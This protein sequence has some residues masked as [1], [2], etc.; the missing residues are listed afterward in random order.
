[1]KTSSI[2]A[3]LKVLV[4]VMFMLGC[5]AASAEKPKYVGANYTNSKSYAVRNVRYYLKDK[6]QAKHHKE[7]G[8]ASWYCCYGKGAKTADGSLYSKHSMTAAHKTLP[9]GSLVKVTNTRN[10]KSVTVEINDRGPFSK[11]RVIDLTPAAFAAIES[12]SLGLAK[13]K[14]EVIGFKY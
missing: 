5:V 1:M 6:Q 13:V 3:K 9:F 7:Q 2:L 11:G 8:S 12:K 4:L 10:G 14:L